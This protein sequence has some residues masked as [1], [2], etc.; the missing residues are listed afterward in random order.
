MSSPPPSFKETLCTPK[1][2]YNLGIQ[3]IPC[4]DSDLS[5]HL[6]KCYF[7]HMIRLMKQKESNREDD[8][9]I[10]DGDFQRD[11]VREMLRYNPC[12]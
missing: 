11:Q 9:D 12:N 8:G 1:L 6:S 10:E 2:Q 3:I 5:S 7:N 4:I